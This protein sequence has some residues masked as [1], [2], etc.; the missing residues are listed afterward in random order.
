MDW[1]DA[2]EC[3]C[4]SHRLPQTAARIQATRTINV[5]VAAASCVRDSNAAKSSASEIVAAMPS[6]LD[7]AKNRLHG[8]SY[9]SA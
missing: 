7:D 8:V 1:Q 6:S 3:K 2:Q 5:V 4:A 9:S